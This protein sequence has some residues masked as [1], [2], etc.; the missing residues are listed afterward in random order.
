MP[1]NEILENE[2]EQSPEWLWGKPSKFP[3]KELLSS[4]TVFYPGAGLDAHPINIFAGASAAHCFVYVDSAGDKSKVKEWLN[5][6]NVES[7]SVSQGYSRIRGY[8]PIFVSE[9]DKKEFFPRGYNGLLNP[10]VGKSEFRWGLWAVLERCD[11]PDDKA[12]NRERI[13]ICYLGCEGVA[14]FDHFWAKNIP[15]YAM[16]LDSYAMGGGS[17]EWGGPG[18]PLHK[19]AKRKKALPKWLITGNTAVAWPGYEGPIGNQSGGMWGH[20]RRFFRY[21]DGGGNKMYTD[22]YSEKL[23]TNYISAQQLNNNS[24]EENIYY[25]AT[26]NGI[27]ARSLDLSSPYVFCA[28]TGEGNGNKPEYRLQA[29]LV[30]KAKANNWILPIPGKDWVLI[31]TER[32][33]AKTTGHKKPDLIAYSQQ[34]NAY[35]ILELKKERNGNRERGK[36]ELIKYHALL[37]KEREGANTV[38]GKNVPAQNIKSYLVWPGL[39]KSTDGLFFPREFSDRQITGVPVQLGVIECWNLAALTMENS[40]EYFNNNKL[41]IKLQGDYVYAPIRN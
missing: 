24:T 30:K 21:L 9:G 31:D 4:R 23:H 6:E 19:A 28:N 27:T 18:T 38:Y 22:T 1:K 17:G 13:L 40:T 37:S 16:L 2:R 12:E 33:F 34:E 15:V 8:R 14:A 26:P 7:D 36:D 32:N 11:S 39:G 25:C 20:S 35:I 41:E 10:Q 3:R 29:Y 5:A